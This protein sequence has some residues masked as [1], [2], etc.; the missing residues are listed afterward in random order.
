MVT[1]MERPWTKDKTTWWTWMAMG[2]DATRMATLK[3]YSET[4]TYVSIN[5][6]SWCRELFT[7]YMIAN[8]LQSQQEMQ[9]DYIK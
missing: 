8:T 5:L 7:K 9:I 1:E 6:T 3:W 2:K 4:E